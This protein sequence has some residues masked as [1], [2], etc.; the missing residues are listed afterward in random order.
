MKLSSLKPCAY[1]NKALI[2]K[3]TMHFYIVTSTMA[4]INPVHANQVMGMTQFFQ[5]NLALAEVFAGSDPVTVVSEH[6]KTMEDKIMLCMECWYSNG[7]GAMLEHINRKKEE[8]NA[9]LTQ[10]S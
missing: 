7:L 9:S 3:H 2:E 6:D 10:A 5:G 8:K 4:L 1:C